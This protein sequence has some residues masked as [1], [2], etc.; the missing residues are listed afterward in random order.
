MQKA[1]LFDLDGT[2]VDNMNYH[3]KAWK[4]IA[5]EEGSD[6]DEKT[7]YKLVYGKN[8]EILTRILDDRKLT[9]EELK[10]LVDKKDALYREKYRPHLAL[11]EGLQQFLDEAHEAGVKMAIAS[12]SAVANVDLVLDGLNLRRYFQGIVTGVEVKKSKPDPATF[13]EAAKKIG[14]LPNQC[15]VFEDVPQGVEAAQHAEM[16]AVAIL[17]THPREAFEPY[18]NVLEMVQ[19]YRFVKVDD[20]LYLAKSI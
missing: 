19:D 5:D 6:K 13:I 10:R 7:I 18:P 14:V 9:D 15:I 20:L 16:N 8:T 1:F 3:L 17:T 2:L 4:A 12:G 11:I